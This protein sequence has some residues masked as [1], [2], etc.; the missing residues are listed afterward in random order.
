MLICRT[1]TQKENTGCCTHWGTICQQFKNCLKP[2]SKNNGSTGE[3]AEHCQLR[4]GAQLYVQAHW[5][6]FL[7]W[8]EGSSAGEVELYG[9]ELQQNVL[10]YFLSGWYTKLEHRSN[11]FTA[12]VESIVLL[13]SRIF[14]NITNSVRH[15]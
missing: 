5:L 8:G 9:E 13:H 4:L 1:V 15:L 6:V 11:Y 7:E 10:T 2:V 3:P 14:H 12:N